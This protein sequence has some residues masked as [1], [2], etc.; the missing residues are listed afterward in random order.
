MR[1]RTA[2]RSCLCGIGLAA[3]LAAGCRGAPVDYEMRLAGTTVVGPDL[4]SIQYRPIVLDEPVEAIIGAQGSPAFNFA[5]GK[6]FFLALALPPRVG[7]ICLTV[8]SRAVGTDLFAPEVLL[9]DDRFEVRRAFPFTGLEFSGDSYRRAIFINE[10]NAGERFVL[11]YTS[12]RAAS[13]SQETLRVQ[14]IP[15]VVVGPGFMYAGNFGGQESKV[16]LKHALGGVV[17]VTLTE[18]KPAKATH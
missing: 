8:V 5:S 11:I 7:R 12:P 17:E 9:L 18:Y 15:V 2:R 13:A 4:G 10:E 1:R 16:K 6:S 14:Q 3:I